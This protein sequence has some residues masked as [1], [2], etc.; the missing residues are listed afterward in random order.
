VSESPPRAK[1]FVLPPTPSEIMSSCDR[2]SKYQNKR[3]TSNNGKKSLFYKKSV[4]RN[5]EEKI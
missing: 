3:V 4:K 1:V 5:E 2:Q